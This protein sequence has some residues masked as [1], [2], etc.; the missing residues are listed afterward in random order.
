[1]KVL[2]ALFALS[3]LT[4]GC[5][6]SETE[7]LR[8]SELIV[9]GVAFSNSEVNTSGSSENCGV[10]ITS[11]S[12]DTPEG[13]PMYRAELNTLQDGTIASF[14]L[15]EFETGKTYS[16]PDF[17]P[18]ASVSQRKF[19]SS[20][21]FLNL[22]L[23]GV[24][25]END[26]NETKMFKLTSNQFAIQTTLCASEL[27]N[28]HYNLF[29][30][31]INGVNFL[32]QSNSN[33]ERV[34]IRSEQGY[35]VIWECNTLFKNLPSGTYPL[36]SATSP[37]LRLMRYK[38]ALKSTLSFNYSPNEWDEYTIVSGTITISP[39]SGSLTSGTFSCNFSMPG[40]SQVFELT[41]GR[42]S[43]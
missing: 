28:M 39:P 29:E 30:Q 12:F 33:G 41:Q 20:D 11:I 22:L 24:V 36:G 25:Y 16:L 2:T 15:H 4:F 40:S 26:G 31:K 34:F 17:F 35:F 19:D 5:E 13:V 18:M 8:T 43:F 23:E 1:M 7:I 38:G 6:N 27:P 9:N 42:F 32:K 10:V 14:D 37:R 3:F 21:S